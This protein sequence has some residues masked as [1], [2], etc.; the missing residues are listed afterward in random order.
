MLLCYA[1]PLKLGRR[2]PGLPS[3]SRAGANLAPGRC[4]AEVCLCA[5][6]PRLIPGPL[7]G[8][9]LAPIGFIDVDGLLGVLLLALRAVA[10][11][12]ALRGTSGAIALLVIL[13][14]AA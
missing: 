8:P 6:Q 5:K 10:A 4:M 7:S 12:V 11:L 1:M 2:A 14:V 9:G 3:F 13:L